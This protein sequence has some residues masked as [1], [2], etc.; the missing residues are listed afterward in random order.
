LPV[1]SPPLSRSVDAARLALSL[2]RFRFGGSA[3]G[4]S[5]RYHTQQKSLSYIV[6]LE[7]SDPIRSV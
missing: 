4:V 7:S 6:T 5:R 2:Y 3:D 1:T